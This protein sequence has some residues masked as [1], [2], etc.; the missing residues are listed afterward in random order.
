MEAPPFLGMLPTNKSDD[1][2][3]GSTS[4][5]SIG[6]TSPLSPNRGL[7]RRLSSDALHSRP[8][9]DRPPS[10]RRLSRLRIK[11]TAESA[12]AET[13]ADSDEDDSAASLHSNLLT[14]REVLSGPNTP[15]E[16]LS[17][18]QMDLNS[19]QEGSDLDQ[20]AV[21]ALLNNR[22]EDP[23]TVVAMFE[24][25]KVLGRPDG[26][27]QVLAEAG[28]FEAI[29]AALRAH[30]QHSSVQ[31]HGC[32]ALRNICR[33]G[34]DSGSAT[35]PLLTHAATAGVIDVV[36]EGMKQHERH[37]GVQQHGSATLAAMTFG[38]GPD[39]CKRRQQ[40]GRQAVL[41]LVDAIRNHPGDVGVQRFSC[42]GLGILCGGTDEAETAEREQRAFTT[43]A[44]GAIVHTID[45]H[46]DYEVSLDS[47]AALYAIVTGSPK[48]K[49][50][51]KNTFA[52]FDKWMQD[53]FLN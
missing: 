1:S 38:E 43:G 12:A 22:N 31:H 52:G 10:E 29:V 16:V 53:P 46:P 32:M 30:P 25:L 15:R 35:Q 39:G 37:K 6:T 44:V 41:V 5:R 40:A 27:A 14:P 51:A 33:Q 9:I 34:E 20:K 36:I 18:S 23:R 7:L 28:A 13:D 11:A 49:E 3:R 2:S 26:S 42:I 8:S 24:R 47:R 17:S 21:V 50:E 4:A 45:N 48:L 19:I